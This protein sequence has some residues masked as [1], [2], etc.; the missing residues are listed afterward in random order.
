MKTY[1]VTSWFDTQLQSY[2]ITTLGIDGALY[3]MPAALNGEATGAIYFSDSLCT[4]SFAAVSKSVT[5]APTYALDQVSGST[6]A[7]QFTDVYTIVASITGP[8]GTADGGGPYVYTN[9]NGTC[10][11]EAVGASSFLFYSVAA[12]P[13]SQMVKVS[14]G[15]D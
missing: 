3:C 6:A 14:T 7:S 8:V 12:V 15:H 4:Q 11:A 10:F 9:F 5:A 13:L 1:S 2:C